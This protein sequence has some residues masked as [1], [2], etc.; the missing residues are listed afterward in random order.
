MCGSKVLV[1][2]LSCLLVCALVYINFYLHQCGM[3]SDYT[4]ESIRVFSA[5]E[6]TTNTKLKTTVE[7]SPSSS[8]TMRHNTVRP[9]S[10]TPPVPA[11][12]PSLD[13]P[14]LLNGANPAGD[15][16]GV[17]HRLGRDLPGT[18]GLEARATRALVDSSSGFPV[19]PSTTKFS[20]RP[21]AFL[22]AYLDWH[23][24]VTDTHSS[25]PCSKRPNAIIYAMTGAGFGNAISGI[26]G[27]L[28]AAL[29]MQR[30]LLVDWTKPHSVEHVFHLPQGTQWGVEPGLKALCLGKTQIASVKSR[31]DEF[32]DENPPSKWYPGGFPV[33]SSSRTDPV[34][35]YASNG[36]GIAR[37]AVFTSRD[38]APASLKTLRVLFAKSRPAIGSGLGNLGDSVRAHVDNVD[39][40]SGR[41]SISGDVPRVAAGHDDINGS[42]KTTIPSK[43][44]ENFVPLALQL[45]FG[46]P[47]QAVLDVL[48]PVFAG[49]RGNFVVGVQVRTGSS[50]TS[51]YP[52][53]AA[54]DEK[55]AFSCAKLVAG[56]AVRTGRAALGKVRYFVSS[57]AEHVIDAA[58]AAFGTDNTLA[59]AGR[60]THTSTKSGKGISALATTVANLVA[61]SRADFGIRS[62]TSS[63]SRNG[64][65]IGG[66]QDLYFVAT[67]CGKGRLKRSRCK[68][69]DLLP[70]VS[71]DACSNLEKLAQEN[72]N[73]DNRKI[74]AMLTSLAKSWHARGIPKLRTDDV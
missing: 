18:A 46:R 64:F 56:W 63:F 43:G 6:A 41:E 23:A 3:S 7:Q 66:T 53:L 47:T 45:F 67:G 11:A 35:R 25:L 30:V 40:G 44:G 1:P 4:R 10:S 26:T 69:H 19:F 31:G 61:L 17:P 52:L 34:I 74:D 5:L 59:V 37:T 13:K 24:A 48:Q 58:R 50:A 9:N 22:Q 12:K 8:L 38:S 39:N 55:K 15:E 54:G 21:R 70:W 16:A 57:D 28:L 68:P 60:I 27:A 42:H 36:N 2:I 51:D 33:F 20:G 73:K 72:G 32:Y 14:P 65:A 29:A 62:L 49:M 71:R